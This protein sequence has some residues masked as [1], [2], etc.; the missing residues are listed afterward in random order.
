[1]RWF[2]VGAVSALSFFP[3]RPLRRFVRHHFRRAGQWNAA[4]IEA[5]TAFGLSWR[6]RIMN[7]S[8]RPDRVLVTF[9]SALDAI[10]D[11]VFPFDCLDVEDKADL[12]YSVAYDAVWERGLRLAN[13]DEVASSLPQS[14][15]LHFEE[16]GPVLVMSDDLILCG[17]TSEPLIRTMARD[18]GT[19]L[20]KLV[21]RQ[22]DDLDH[23]LDIIGGP[24]DKEISFELLL[25]LLD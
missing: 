12:V 19:T 7:S 4:F 13:L 14:L 3:E 1:M 15:R 24:M 21:D 16:V 10:R 20:A 11:H 25:S 22:L 9:R 23:L 8:I 18:C 6:E 2:H 5:W 17:M